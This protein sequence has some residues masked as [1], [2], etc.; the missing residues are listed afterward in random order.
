MNRIEEAVVDSFNQDALKHLAEGSS[1][2]FW[3]RDDLLLIGD[4]HASRYVEFAKNGGNPGQALHESQGGCLQ[5]RRGGCPT[6]SWVDPVSLKE[7]IRRFS[8]TKVAHTD[9]S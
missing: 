2:G 9:L 8:Q 3:M 5:H 4:N 7:T 1:T 6:E